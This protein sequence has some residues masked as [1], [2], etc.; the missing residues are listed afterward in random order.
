[1]FVMSIRF[2]LIYFTINDVNVVFFGENMH[3]SEEASEQETLG[4]QRSM[5][6]TNDV[7]TDFLLFLSKHHQRDAKAVVLYRVK[8]KSSVKELKRGN[9]VTLGHQSFDYE[10][11]LEVTV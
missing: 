1:M 11:D 7:T 3:E 10:G 6:I 8:G 2:I 5:I 4:Q 9:T